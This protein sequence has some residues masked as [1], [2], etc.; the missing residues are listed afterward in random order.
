MLEQ[1]LELAKISAWANKKFR[2]SLKESF[3]DLKDITTPY[4]S[5]LELIYHIFSATYFWLRRIGYADY[6]IRPAKDLTNVN[7]LFSQ[8]EVI[9][10][11]LIEFIELM[12]SENNPATHSFKYTT[13]KGL[14]FEIP[15]HVLIL[16][17]F[18]HGYY[19]RG[20]L[21]YV[22]RMNNKPPMPQTDSL[23]YFRE[24]SAK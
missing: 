3:T 12:R 5:F 13:A 20:Q 2:D 4:G 9:D 15:L 7:N 10:Q 18:N 6:T 23:V 24:I 11:K 21:A 1:E 19:H 17:L 16:Q 22:V 14:E 8:W